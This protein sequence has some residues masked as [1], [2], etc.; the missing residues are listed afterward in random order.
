VVCRG[1]LTPDA[2]RTDVLSAGAAGAFESVIRHCVPGSTP[3]AWGGS[4][5]ADRHGPGWLDPWVGRI[6]LTRMTCTCEARGPRA[7]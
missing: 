6:A 4:P 1:H 3:R 2:R 5:F 7:D